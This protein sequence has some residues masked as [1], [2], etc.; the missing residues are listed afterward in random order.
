MENTTKKTITKKELKALLSV[1]NKELKLD[2]EKISLSLAKQL[3]KG[4]KGYFLYLNN[5]KKIDEEIAKELSQFKGYY[6][7]LD[8]LKK[9]DQEIAKELSQFKGTILSL[10][11]IESFSKEVLKELAS[12]QGN[13]YLEKTNEE[14]LYNFSFF[15][16]NFKGKVFFYWLTSYELNKFNFNHYGK[17][18]INDYNEK[19]IERIEQEKEEFILLE[20]FLPLEKMESLFLSINERYSDDFFKHDK[21]S[22]S[23]NGGKYVF[24]WSIGEAGSHLYLL[25]D[26]ETKGL[27]E[28]C[29]FQNYT[30]NKYYTV[31]KKGVKEITSKE[32]F[33]K[34]FDKIEKT[35]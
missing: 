1:P 19:E 23:C 6:L 16:F 4:F 13:L 27:I 26:K 3:I 17:N 2:I 22:I 34:N 35:V 28:D 33:L 15:L 9:I 7:F 14:S 30:D 12:F 5:L 25:S 24:F 31:S 21:S 11:G 29:I 20:D 18:K 32:D 8:G 10:N